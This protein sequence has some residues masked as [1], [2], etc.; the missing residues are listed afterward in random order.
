MALEVRPPAGCDDIRQLLIMYGVLL[1]C[2]SGS[3][4]LNCCRSLRL[5]RQSFISGN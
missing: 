4:H 3:D 2:R 5:I 1:T